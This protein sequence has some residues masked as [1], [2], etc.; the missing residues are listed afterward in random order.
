[1]PNVLESLPSTSMAFKVLI[2]SFLVSLTLAQDPLKDALN[3]VQVF[4]NPAHPEFDTEF[5]NE[6][7]T[8]LDYLDPRLVTSVGAQWDGMLQYA[9]SQGTPEDPWQPCN[10]R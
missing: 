8:C 5:Y 7:I 1:M 4:M 9:E 2:F 3:G 10:L 6:L